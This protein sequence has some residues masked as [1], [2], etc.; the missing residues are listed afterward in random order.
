MS[1]LPSQ[2][3]KFLCKNACGREAQCEC[4]CK[5]AHYC[6]RVC[7]S[8]PP[9]PF[10]AFFLHS[11]A[12]V[13]SVGL[14]VGPPLLHVESTHRSTHRSVRCREAGSLTHHHRSFGRAGMPGEGLPQPRAI[15]HGGGERWPS[16][17]CFPCDTQRAQAA[18]RVFN[19][20]AGGPGMRRR[21]LTCVTSKEGHEALFCWKSKGMTGRDEKSGGEGV[22]GSHDVVC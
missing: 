17:V 15:L 10:R 12:R 9:L 4:P 5:Q 22:I 19:G 11:R 6:S 2:E 7:F 16:G 3:P 8:S 21:Q 14:W 20:R 1:A 13:V 18:H